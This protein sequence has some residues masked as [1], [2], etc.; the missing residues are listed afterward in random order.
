MQL[1]QSRQAVRVIS[2]QWQEDDGGGFLDLSNDVVYS[3]VT[4]NT[5]TLTNPGMGMD[6]YDYRVILTTGTCDVTSPPAN[7]TVHELATVIDDPDNATTCEQGGASFTV[8]ASGPGLDYQWQEDDG[9]GW[10][11]IT[12]GGIYS[13]ATSNTLT[14]TGVTAGMNNNDYRCIL[15]TTGDCE[16][17]SAAA[18]LTVQ[19]LANI[20]NLPDNDETCDGGNA[21]F[22]VTASGPGLDYQWQEHDGGSWT[23]ITDGGIYGGATTNTLTLTGADLTMDTYDYRCVLTTT[24][25]CET[26][27]DPANLTVHP[28]ATITTQPNSPTAC[29]EGTA[30]FT[31]DA[32]GPGLTYRWQEFDGTDWNNLADAGIYSG[33]TTDELTISGMPIGMDGTQYRCVLTTTGSCAVPSNAGTLNLNPLPTPSI[34]GA[35]NVCLNDSEEYTTANIGGHT[36]SWSVTNGSISGVSDNNTVTIDWDGTTGAASVSVTETITATG[37]NATTPD[38][39]VIVNPAAP[40]PAGAITGADVV[41]QNETGVAYSI[42]AVADAANYVWTVPAGATI[43]SGAGT[44]AITVDYAPTA[45]N[46]TI[47]VYAENG[48]GAGAAATLGITVNTMPVG[49]DDT[50]AEC[51]DETLGYDLQDNID[52]LG[53][54]VASTFVWSAA[55]NG[56]VTGESTADQS[57]GTINDAINNITGSDQAVVYTVTPTGVNS[58]PG[59]DF[60]ITITIRSEP[61]G[62]DDNISTCSDVALSYNLQTANINTLGNGQAATFSW[63]ATANGDVAGESTTAQTGG[64]INDQLTNT[65]S[66]DQVVVYTVT[67]TGTNGCEGAPFTVSVTVESEPEGVND[68]H[69]SCSS[70]GVGY[71]LQVDNINTLGNSQPAS[72]SWVATPNADVT[73]ESTTAQTGG[74]I[75][76]VLTNTTGSDELVVYTVTPTGSNGCAGD[77]FTVT[78]TVQSEPVG[79]DDTDNSCSGEAFDYDLQANVTAGNGMTANYSWIA[80]DNPNVTGEST[81]AQSGDEIDDLITNISGSDQVVEYTVTPTATNGCEGDDFTIEVTIASEP[82]GDDDN[83]ST[84]SDVALTYNLQTANINTLGNGQA[85]TFSWVATAN[86]DVAGESTT[87][88]TG[89]TINDQLTNTSSVDQVVVYTVTPTG[90]NSCEG[91]PFTVSVTV[92]SEPE[93]VNDTHPSCSSTGVGYDL[94]VDNINTLGNSQP[95]SFSWVATPNADVAGESTTAQTGGT[96]NDV[97]TNTTGSDELVVYTVTPTGSNGCAGDDFTVTVTVQSEPVGTDDTDNS[98]SGEAFDYDLQANVTAGNGMTANFSWIAVDNP[99]VTGESTI[100]QS[101]DEIDDL[102]TNISGS[103]QVVEYTVTPTATNGCEGDDF[104]IEVTIASEPEGD[105]AN[106]FT[107]SDVALT[108]N[109]QTANI[110]TLGNGQAATFSWVATANGDV[111]GESTTAQTGG[112]IDDQLTNTTGSDQ[113][114]E[115]TVTPTGTNSC[116]GES[117]T[118]NVTVR[119][120]PIGADDSDQICSAESPNYDL[121]ANV[122]GE[123]GQSSN[124]SWVAASNPNVTGESTAPQSGDFITDLLTNTSGSNQDVVYT[125][126]PIGTN[127][128]TGDPFTITITVQNE[129]DGANHTGVA[130]SDVAISY[131]LQ[132]NIDNLGNGVEATFSWVAAANPN[133][134][135]ES[136]AA[137]SGSIIDDVVENHTGADETLVYTITPTSTAGCVGDPF[138]V[139]ITVRSAP[140]LTIPLLQTVCSDVAANRT[141]TVSNGMTGVTYEW[142]STCIVDHH[143]FQRRNSRSCRIDRSDYRSVQQ[144]HRNP[145]DCYLHRG[146]DQRRW[147]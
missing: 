96:I 57:G 135:G 78:V 20:T 104:T 43:A 132:E 73:G 71:D 47:E 88:Q 46:L 140:I 133:V 3:N 24:G 2:Y 93:G 127:G 117:F 145:A 4:T 41:C 89:G 85:A 26:E 106:I 76:D 8:D 107:C 139:V 21:S 131:D 87:A 17:N 109:L 11:D 147:L 52:N 51:S 146:T 16:L 143:R 90:T 129:P 74:T 138:T 118:I 101:G 27:S 84:C 114:V 55:A 116:E 13:G 12:N 130:C 70:T 82:E 108:Y 18:T 100:A 81:I 126:T 123:N 1:L 99:N 141:L 110:N 15:I 53:N 86:G 48:C 14:L 62:D 19:P 31:I 121:Q 66:V 134:T 30:L 32:T 28:Y 75:N 125:V 9:G 37:C 64:T 124:F 113:V 35:D 95:A 63:V 33:V 38:Y 91:A 120:T 49:V 29:A 58:C 102:I 10:T 137:Q 136:L 5:L 68:T 7:L 77:D 36:Y 115:Y 60:E 6:T 23:N 34:G 69:P 80:V 79:T 40:G 97:L 103:D 122:N 44:T 111:A 128:C 59:D 61:E 56:N 45:S 54:G 22:S 72:F 65:S 112:T 39:D 25:S 144:Y 67:P 98:C 83:I 119:S 42:A 92:E 94:Q 105:D 50:D 142:G